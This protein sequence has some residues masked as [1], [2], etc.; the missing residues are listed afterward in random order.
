MAHQKED[1]R[2][3]I[4]QIVSSIEPFDTIEEEQIGFVLKWI[5]SG[6]EIFRISKPADPDIHLVSYFALLSPEENKI[7]LVD[8]KK[9]N[10][11]LPPGGHIEPGE[12]PKEAVKRE[13][14]EELGIEATFLIDPPLFLT[15]SRTTEDSHFSSHTDVSLWYV[16]KG[17]SDWHL[18]FDKEEFNEIKWFDLNKIPFELSD[19][20]MDRFLKKLSLNKIINYI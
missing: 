16:L 10:L 19:P 14:Q 12:H 5:A 9:A 17:S 7:L 13:I 11:W 2:S 15:I 18:D 3:I 8:H 4:S 6:D 1:I 20:N